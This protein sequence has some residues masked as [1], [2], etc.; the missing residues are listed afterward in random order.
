[1]FDILEIAFFNKISLSSQDNRTGVGKNVFKYNEFV[2]SRC[3]WNLNET[4]AT[5][6][7]TEKRRTEEEISHGIQYEHHLLKYLSLVL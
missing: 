5:H 7:G 6:E 3:Q 1:M 4:K 2:F